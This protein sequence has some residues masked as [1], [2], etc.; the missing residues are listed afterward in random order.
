M[1]CNICR[2]IVLYND[3][4]PPANEPHDKWQYIAFGY[5]DGIKIGEN[6]FQDGRCSLEELWD[7]DVSQAQELEGKYSTQIIYGFRSEEVGKNYDKFFWKEG[8]GEETEYPFIFV[9]LV[10][11]GIGKEKAEIGYREELERK[12]SEGN[13]RKVITYLTL[14]NSSMILIVLCRDYEDGA[15]LIDGFHRKEKESLLRTIGIELSYSYTVA[16]VQKKFLNS[17]KVERLNRKK[18]GRVYIYAIERHPGSIEYVRQQINESCDSDKPV[19]KESILGC[20]DE[21]MVIEDVSWDKFLALFKDVDGKLNHSSLQYGSSFIGLTTIIANQQDETGTQKGRVEKHREICISPFQEACRQLGMKLRKLIFKI[22]EEKEG[23]SSCTLER[24]LY[25]ITNALQKFDNTPILDYVYCS[26]YLPIYMVLQIMKEAESIVR[27]DFYNC[28]YEF[29]KDLNLCAQNSVRSE[30]QFTQSLDLDIRIYNAPVRLNAFYNAFLYYMKKFLNKTGEQS[31]PMHE[32]EFLTCLGVTDNVQVREL[33]K[34]IS[35]NKRLFFVSVPEN[36]TY[37]MR[38]MLVMLGHE[39]GHFVGQAVRNREYRYE[40]AIKIMT[41]ITA[42]FFRIKLRKTSPDV[43]NE[44][45]WKNFNQKFERYLKVQLD[46]LGEKDYLREYKFQGCGERELDSFIRLYQK[47]KYYTH[48]LGETLM[49]SIGEVLVGKR[50]ELFGYLREKEYLHWLEKDISQA[51]TKQREFTEKIGDIIQATNGYFY[52]NPK[53][54][55]MMSAIGMMISLF[56]ECEADLVVILTLELSLEDYLYAIWK[57]ASDQGKHNWKM[58]AETVV[59]SGL[60]AY[61]MNYEISEN[62]FRWTDEE[63]VNNQKS[64]DYKIQEM[65]WDIQNFIRGY[66]GQEE[67]KAKLSSAFQTVDA[68]LDSEVLECIAAYLL[69]CKKSFQQAFEKKAGADEQMISELKQ[70]QQQLMEIYRLASE[71]VE[72]LVWDMQKY[73][74]QYKQCLQEEIRRHGEEE[75][76]Q[77]V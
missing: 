29:V 62:G 26:M 67:K 27:G 59:R 50:E 14:D 21:V 70:E 10:Q 8:L 23:F 24:Y 53:Q 4:L 37:D 31:F 61:C 19:R 20:N 52:W 64:G 16:A 22:S 28:F 63:L 5:F 74:E 73:I 58:P 1:V 42:N 11:G 57:S 40:S 25:Q 13:K 56:K 35:N 17:P 32:Y 41:V 46:N 33:F 60:V 39:V 77:G 7:Y 2:P 48:C 18:A 12:L 51:A 3:F 47:Y 72:D 38:L 76:G 65:V 34:N 44:E 6:I 54:F 69:K 66:L 15:T 68:F 75:T 71:N 55:T 49:D 9:T 43:Q 30:R 36:Q 45:F